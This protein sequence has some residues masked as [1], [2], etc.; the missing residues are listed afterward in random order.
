MRKRHTISNTNRLNNSNRRRQLLKRMQL[1]VMSR[2]QHF[3]G[4]EFDQEHTEPC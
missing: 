2:R 3:Q 4:L 1:K